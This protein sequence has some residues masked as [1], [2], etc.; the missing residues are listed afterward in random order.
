MSNDP[1]PDSKDYPNPEDYR[2]AINAWLDRH[3]GM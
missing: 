2:K 3:P 1:Y